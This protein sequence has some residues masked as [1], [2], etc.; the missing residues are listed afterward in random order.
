MEEVVVQTYMEGNDH[1]WSLSY[2][3]TDN[4][5]SG[6]TGHRNC[7]VDTHPIHTPNCTYM[8][9]VSPSFRLCSGS[10]HEGQARQHGWLA[11]FA[12]WTSSNMIFTASSA[13]CSLLTNNQSSTAGNLSVPLGGRGNRGQGTAGFPL[14]DYLCFHVGVHNRLPAMCTGLPL[15]LAGLHCVGKLEILCVSVRRGRGRREGGARGECAELSVFSFL[16]Y[17]LPQLPRS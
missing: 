12:V 2:H 14:L 4:A 11:Q 13:D 16:G 9:G 15:S 17:R 10:S 1:K 7:S 3:L 5:C 8:S 6:Y